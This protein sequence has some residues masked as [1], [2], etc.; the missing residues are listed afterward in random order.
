MDID[1]MDD[2]I[3]ES[4]KDTLNPKGGSYKKEKKKLN[5]CNKMFHPESYCIMNK[6][7]LMEKVLQQHNVVDYI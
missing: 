4:S 6:I 3:I 5:H 1:D 7:D 2:E